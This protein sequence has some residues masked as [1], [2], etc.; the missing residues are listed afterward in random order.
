MAR[1]YRHRLASSLVAALVVPVLGMAGCAAGLGGAAAS[2]G[3]ADP[4]TL[5]LTFFDGVGLSA[6]TRAALRAEVRAAFSTLA[7]RVRW[8]APERPAAGD[9]ASF[10]VVLLTQEPSALG[11][12]P[13]ALGG[14][15]RQP[16][17]T[18]YLFAPPLQRIVRGARR[19]PAAVDPA[20]LGRA[21][22]RVLVHEL[23]HTLAPERGHARNGLMAPG[24]TRD[25]LLARR[26][27]I[28]AETR[29][30]VA[31]A[32]RRLASPHRRCAPRAA[33]ASRARPPRLR[34][35]SSAISPK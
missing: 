3:R 24:L 31:A 10:T 32:L 12:A 27:P 25:Q 34:L 21:Y 28:D 18:V 35:P 14:A 19:R 23:I 9:P 20:A 15:L 13:Q 29:R 16:S 5:M 2:S 7:G 11:L 33:G 8:R 22:A 1:S 17:R 6:V 26:L 30:A 4:P